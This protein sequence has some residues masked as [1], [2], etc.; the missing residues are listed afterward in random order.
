MDTY[1][2]HFDG[3][4]AL[5]NLDTAATSADRFGELQRAFAAQAG[6]GA[7]DYA[8]MMRLDR[9]FVAEGLF[10]HSELAGPNGASYEVVRFPTTTD[11]QVERARAFIRRSFDCV[12]LRVLRIS[13]LIDFTPLPPP[14]SCDPIAPKHSTHRGLHG[15]L[16]CSDCQGRLGAAAVPA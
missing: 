8:D 11:D 3:I 14:C 16:V 12:R 2:I 5:L 13:R 10:Y 4:G 1:L 15:W 7:S 6:G 9:G